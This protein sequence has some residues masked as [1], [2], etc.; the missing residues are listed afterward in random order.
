M[1]TSKTITEIIENHSEFSG[2]W[3][4]C[5]KICFKSILINNEIAY[6]TVMKSSGIGGGGAGVASAPPKVLIC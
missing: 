1:L 5:K 6:D 3:N 4:C 2:C